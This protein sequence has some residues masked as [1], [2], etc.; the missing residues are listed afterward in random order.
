MERKH[1][2]RQRKT[3]FT[4]GTNGPDAPGV[5]Q[6]TPQGTQR[7]KVGPKPGSISAGDPFPAIKHVGG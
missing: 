3:P 7:A 5:P 2:A 6:Q 1:A 4:E